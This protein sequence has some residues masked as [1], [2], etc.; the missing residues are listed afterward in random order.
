[1]VS[2]THRVGVDVE[3]LNEKIEQIQHKFI[4]EAELQV[5]NVQSPMP[6]I[7]CL[8]LLKPNILPK[9]L[10]SQKKRMKRIVL[11]SLIYSAVFFAVSY[12]HL[13]VYKR[14]KL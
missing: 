1:M 7:Q 10:V 11:L 5:L 3:L 8:T 6:A 14:Q 13:D 12:T 9:R 2:K 4:Y